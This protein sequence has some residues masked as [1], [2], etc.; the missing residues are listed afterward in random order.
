[1]RRRLAEGI[2]S[3]AAAAQEIRTTSTQARED[4]RAARERFA[5]LADRLEAEIGGGG[6][7]LRGAAAEA[8]AA[9]RAARELFGGEDLR[10]AAGE[11]RAF[12]ERVV[13]IAERIEETLLALREGLDRGK[14]DLDE[15]LLAVRATAREA[16]EFFGRLRDNPAALLRGSATRERE[17]PGAAPR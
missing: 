6:S 12:S 8:E 17:I 13:P 11:I 16:G 3:F 4:L 14:R 10:V 2:E 5:A 9:A 1:M 15:V 7:A